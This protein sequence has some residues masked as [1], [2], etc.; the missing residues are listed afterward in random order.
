MKISK[1]KKYK[2]S[3]ISMIDSFP[4][5]SF[6][7]RNVKNY[8]VFLSIDPTLDHVEYHGST[9]EDAITSAFVSLK[10]MK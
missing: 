9:L 3:L 6:I 10:R 5:T 7:V 2:L 4:A 8:T 1:K